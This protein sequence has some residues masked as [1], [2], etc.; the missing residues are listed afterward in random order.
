MNRVFRPL[1]PVFLH[2]ASSSELFMKGM[3]VRALQ[4]IPKELC[5]ALPFN[6]AVYGQ[7]SLC[8]QHLGLPYSVMAILK[9]GE[10]LPQGFPLVSPDDLWNLFDN[11]KSKLIEDKVT[12]DHY[13]EF[14]EKGLASR[15]RVFVNPKVLETEGAEPEKETIASSFYLSTLCLRPSKVKAEFSDEKMNSKVLTLTGK[16]AS[17]FAQA[18]DGTQGNISLL[19]SRCRG[20]IELSERFGRVLPKSAQAIASY[21][22]E[23]RETL[24]LIADLDNPKLL[25]KEFDDQLDEILEAMENEYD[26]V[27]GIKK[28]DRPSLFDEAAKE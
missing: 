21:A 18:F 12:E 27:K 24:K 7:T 19:A 25:D 22:S 2:C 16:E 5:S 13:K 6:C 15:F 26:K 10:E 9:E 14:L 28:D 17:R 1:A 4:G 23:I 11:P 3:S 8:A 20:K